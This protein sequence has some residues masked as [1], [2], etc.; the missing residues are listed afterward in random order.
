M[1]GIFGGSN[2]S[3]AAE[4]LPAALCKRL[5]SRFGDF[6]V[7]AK[8]VHEEVEAMRL[9]VDASFAEEMLLEYIDG[10]LLD[11]STARDEL[12]RSGR[13]DMNPRYRAE[14]DTLCFCLAVLDL[15]R[16]TAVSRSAPTAPRLLQWYSRHYLEEDIAEWWQQAQQAAAESDLLREDAPFWEPLCRLAL[17][18]CKSEVLQ[19]LQR[20][21]A[22][23]D[24][25][26]SSVC[27]L[28]RKMPSQR[29]MDEGR[30]TAVE[31]CQS[32]RE[33]QE[34]A[35]GLLRQVPA[36]HPVRQLLEVYAGC[37]LAAFEANEDV[38]AKMSRTWVEDFI[39]SHAWVFPD[40]RRAEL[41]DLLKAIARR[42]TQENI[43]D[44]DRAFF[45]TLTVDVPELL[46]LLKTMPDRF[47]CYFVV[48]LVDVLYYAGRVPLALDTGDADAV[49]PRDWHLMAYAEELS[50]GD[51]ELRRFALDY[52]RAAGAPAAA[53]LLEKL[54]DQYCEAAANDDGALL[55]ALA[56]LE[57]LGLSQSL[58]RKQCWRRADLLRTSGDVCGAIRWACWAEVALA[59]DGL[60]STVARSLADKDS[61]SN[62]G[63]PA[64]I[65]ELLDT[66]ADDNLP[67]LLAALE[68]SDLEEPLVQ[69]PSATLLAHL[70][71]PK[72]SRPLPS[73]PPSG[74]LCFYSQYA[75]CHALRKAGRPAS[76]WAPVLVGL[77]SKG[78]ASPRAQRVVLK[79]ELL[80]V[81]EQ[82]PAPLDTEEALLLMRVVQTSTA[83]QDH[84]EAWK[85]TGLD[86]EEL[87]RLLG[88]C[89][90]RAI[91]RGP[92]RFG[93]AV[94]VDPVRQAPAMSQ[95]LMA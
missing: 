6:Q 69:F 2:V 19:L 13:W 26:V 24:T 89:L 66:L 61:D 86:L 37:S 70:A 59:A 4:A 67:G 74:R 78:L 11:F 62:G 82:D 45:A 73:M 34:A 93:A 15:V 1:I 52:L 94:T 27:D 7:R 29:Q 75:R 47:P 16:H 90:S 44:V 43:D 83:G 91:L 9:P 80:P 38:A 14:H 48:H 76:L 92:E 28:L 17:A 55:K 30:A 12:R 20:C 68:P 53:Q 81:L 25:Q 31:F 18:D 56:V 36:E 8:N 41:G 87:H 57:D 46:R 21:S 50:S 22:S 63:G 23:A 35:Q 85:S 5:R 88:T 60:D 33:I 84:K 40:L 10:L 72:A 32:M 58:G 95:L 64:R 39:F 65:S 71:P 42:R 77:M 51:Q 49:P 3:T 54:A 79:E